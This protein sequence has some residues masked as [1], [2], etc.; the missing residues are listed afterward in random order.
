M[1]TLKASQQKFNVWFKAVNK[2]YNY[3]LTIQLI[4]TNF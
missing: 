2:N 4:I 1:Y 3:A